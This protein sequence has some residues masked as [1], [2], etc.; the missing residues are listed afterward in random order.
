MKRLITALCITGALVSGPAMAWGDQGHKAI[1]AIAAQLLVGTNAEKQIAALL[2]PGEDMEFS[3]I[4][5]DCAKG[6]FCG[7][8]TDEMKAYTAANPKHQEYHYT[9]TPVQRSAYLPGGVGTSPHDIVQMLKQSIA[10][11]QGRADAQSNPHTLSRRQALLLLAHLASDIHQP[12]HVGSIYLDKNSRIV[13]PL[14]QSDVD[15][16]NIFDMRGDNQLLFADSAYDRRGYP[17]QP[18]APQNVHF[19]WDITTVEEV[20]RRTGVKNATEFAK[21][22]TASKRDVEANTGDPVTWPLQWA[23]DSLLIAKL[24][25]QGVQPGPMKS[26]LDRRGATYLTWPVTVPAG[27]LDTSATTASAQ[28]VKG[29]YH[30]AALLQKI[31][32]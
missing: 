7:P 26:N 22:V 18:I 23:A 2:L 31:W 3:T 13:E 17:D 16:V 30:F 9:N 27:Y 15:G 5:A 29:G 10:V 19:F 25:H 14:I 4:W 1:G 32:P 12:L 6:A 21:V 8:Q 20:Y 28:L 24:A 11:L